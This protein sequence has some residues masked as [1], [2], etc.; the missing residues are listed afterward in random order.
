MKTDLHQLFLKG[1]Q[2]ERVLNLKSNWL[3]TKI[4]QPSFL[5]GEGAFLFHHSRY[6]KRTLWTLTS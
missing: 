5:H 2:R 1:Y 3:K 6:S 4:M